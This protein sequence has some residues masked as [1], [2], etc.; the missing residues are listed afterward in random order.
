VEGQITY[1]FVDASRQ[2][3]Q[4]IAEGRDRIFIKSERI[5]RV[6]AIS[7]E[8][9]YDYLKKKGLISSEEISP[10]SL[11]IVFSR[12]PSRQVLSS[13]FPIVAWSFFPSLQNI[14]TQYQIDYITS[15]DRSKN[16]FWENLK[17]DVGRARNNIRGLLA[18]FRNKHPLLL[19][20]ATWDMGGQDLRNLAFDLFERG[21]Q[22]NLLTYAD[23]KLIAFNRKYRPERR[24]RP[25][26]Y[27]N[28]SDVFFKHAEYTE[29]HGHEWD[30]AHSSHNDRCR[31]SNAWRFGIPIDPK[32]HFDIQYENSKWNLISC[33]LL[34]CH[35]ERCEYKEKSHIN[36]WRNDF[37]KK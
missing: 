32:F 33:T 31:L 25:R 2:L 6:Q 1:L 8:Q 16:N 7:C 5:E 19:P 17:T 15:G 24:K 29:L 34:N 36:V 20:F 14:V 27:K 12:F 9:L 3:F 23:E 26:W 30:S 18:A 11:I 28:D 4:Y 22:G 10:S 21:F 37:N 35:G 13:F